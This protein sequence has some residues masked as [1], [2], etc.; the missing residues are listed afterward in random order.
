MRSKVCY[1][2]Q[3]LLIVLTLQFFFSYYIE[4]FTIFC[5][6]NLQFQNMKL[7]RILVLRSL[8]SIWMARRASCSFVANRAWVLAQY[9]LSCGVGLIYQVEFYPKWLLAIKILLVFELVQGASSKKLISA[10]LNFQL[11]VLVHIRNLA[12]Y[13]EKDTT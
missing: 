1:S 6:R 3:L 5:N 4:Y 12:K 10:F 8:F 2:V 9:D 7:H 11:G 13:L